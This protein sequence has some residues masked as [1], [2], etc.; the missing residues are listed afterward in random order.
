M[1]ARDPVSEI[2]GLFQQKDEIGN[3]MLDN[4][5]GTIDEQIDQARGANLSERAP[6]CRV[7]RHARRNGENA[8]G[9]VLIRG[10]VL[11]P[12]LWALLEV[13]SNADMC[14]GGR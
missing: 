4:V 6:G 8:R 2:Q 7:R 11:S 5:F 9:D 10:A 12:V 13:P 14:A 1:S 3:M